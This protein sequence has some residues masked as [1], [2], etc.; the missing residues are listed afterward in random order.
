MLTGRLGSPP[1]ACYHDATSDGTSDQAAKVPTTG[2]QSPS[3]FPARVPATAASQTEIVAGF[4][5][6]VLADR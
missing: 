2:Q 4:L 6:G 5:A 1:L 3:S